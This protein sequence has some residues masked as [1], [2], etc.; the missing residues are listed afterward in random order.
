MGRPVVHAVVADRLANRQAN[1]SPRI[2]AAALMPLLALALMLV[3]ALA[4]VLARALAPMPAP[5]SA[6]VRM[7][8]LVLAPADALRP[9]F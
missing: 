1:C 2:P 8:E 7:L 5:V 9:H 3:L 6:P 4:P